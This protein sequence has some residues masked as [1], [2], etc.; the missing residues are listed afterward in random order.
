MLK[1]ITFGQYFPAQSVIHSMDA[2]VKMVLVIA[3][4]VFI[5]LTGNV[6]SLMIMTAAVFAVIGASHIPLRVY[7]KCLKPIIPIIILTSILNALY[8]SGGIVLVDFGCYHY[9]AGTDD[10]GVYVG[11]HRTTNPGQFPVDLYYVAY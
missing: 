7:L 8:V 2:R 11:T 5:F 3:L 9:N 4:I 10:R 6:I 1:D